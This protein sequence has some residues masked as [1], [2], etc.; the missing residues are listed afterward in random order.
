[1]TEAG[2]QPLLFTPITIRGV[3]SKNRIVVSPMCQYNSDDGGPGDWQM[4]HIGRLA[5]GG[6]GIIF[7]EETGVEARGRKTYK[8]AGIWDDKHIPMYRKLTDFIKE[9]DAVPA[10]QLG[11][12][13][14]K[15]SCHT[16]TEDW[17]PLEDK[18]AADGMPPWQG[19]A[20]SALDQLPRRFIP[21]AM[22]QN[23]IRTVLDAWREATRRSMDAGYDILEIHGAHGYLIHQFL[24]PVS[25][26][27]NDA[28]GGDRAG[29]MRFALE[30]AE[31][32]RDAW[33]QDKPL[34]FRVSA[35][36]GEGGIWSLEDT[37]A[38]SKEL[39]D[40]D[41]D[42]VDCSS[43]GISG[44]S[45]MPMVPRIE[46]FQA[47]FA[48]RVRR[49]AGIMTIAVGGITQAQQ[50]EDILQSGRADL[51]A[52]AREFLWNADWAAHAAKELGAV[53]PYGQMPH[54][55]A[56]RLRQREKQKEMPINQGGDV[57]QAAYQKIFGDRP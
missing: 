8:C 45:E 10:I 13:G 26:H 55:Y 31:V 49:E 36:D 4:M 39:K 20:P 51:V 50:A 56:Y 11:H 29:R 7:G 34:F 53:D 28:Y 48:D 37:V 27:R 54:E 18:D 33:P 3:T 17:R 41:I 52:L 25:N 15:A 35:V 19:L 46:Q 47:G 1:M 5:V 21:K 12:A 57:T 9:Q 40:R 30:V 16:A 14:R 23:D 38:L 44:D 2:Q 24:S 6:A 32:V 43:G 42:L 22:D